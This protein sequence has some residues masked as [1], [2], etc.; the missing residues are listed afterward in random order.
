MKRTI[1]LLISFCFALLLNAQVSKIIRVPDLPIVVIDPETI[2]P[3][4]LEN[5]FEVVTIDGT[6]YLKVTQNGWNSL[7]TIPQTNIPEDATH[8]KCM[9]KYEEGTSGEPFTGVNTFMQLFSPDW[10]SVGFGGAP[11]SSEFKEYQVALTAKG[12]VGIFQVAA[13]STS[14]WGAISNAIQYIGKVEAIK[15]GNTL[16]SY[17][18]S[19]GDKT[20]QIVSDLNWTITSDQ[21]WLALNKTSGTGTDI[22]NLTAT[23][24]STNSVRVAT[25]TIHA[26]GFDDQM[27]TVTQ[28]GILEITAG[29]LKTAIAGG[30]T[31]LTNLTLTGTIDARDFKTMRDDMPLAE[32]DL[33]GATI[34]AYNGSDGTSIWG[35]NNYAAD[36]VPEFAFCNSNWQGKTSLTSVNLPSGLKSISRFA[37]HSCYGLTSISIPS[38]VSHIGDGAFGWCNNLTALNIPSSVTTIGSGAFSGCS[39]ITAIS[40]PASVISIGTNAFSYFRAP[41]NV[42]ASNPNYSSLDG[43]LFNKAQTS[44]IQ[45]PV[46]KTGTYTIPGSA[47]LIEQYAFQDC[48][49]LTSFSIPA[50]V[51]S[52]GSY[53]FSYCNNVTSIIVSKSVPLDLSSSDGVF[54]GVNTTTCTLNVPY[55]TASRYSAAN[56]W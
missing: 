29:N 42:D 25:V 4:T 35:N 32:L 14:T 6:K 47:V 36:A 20:I 11:S 21:S 46:S 38:M 19:G 26:E 51:T 17:G 53:A 15:V 13:Q 24:F 30:L 48:N 10:N 37:F 40:I 33:S 8:F 56:Q 5:G 54:Y 34:V 52:I 12:T 18:N 2:D 44:L 55:G 16:L 45:C 43:V 39:G 7:T 27:I 1:L 41:I 49:Q 3:S 22:I 28:S 50:S 31:A 23:A 9:A